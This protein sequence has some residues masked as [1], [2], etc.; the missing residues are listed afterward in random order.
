VGIFQ[1]VEVVFRGEHIFHYLSELAG[2]D[3][4]GVVKCTEDIDLLS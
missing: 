1:E 3:T 4:K 2:T